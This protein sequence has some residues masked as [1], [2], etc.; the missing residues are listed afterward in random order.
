MPDKDFTTHLVQG[1]KAILSLDLEHDYGGEGVNGIIL[2]EKL[3]QFL[4]RHKVKLCVF[5]EGRILEQHAGI[6]DLLSGA[7]IDVAQ[8]CYDHRISSGDDIYN[9]EKGLYIFQSRLN[10]HPYGYRAHSY[11]ISKKLLDNLVRLGFL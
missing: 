9:L 11:Q 6:I 8:H 3:L 10:R 2:F 5:V 7:N 4:D 1:R